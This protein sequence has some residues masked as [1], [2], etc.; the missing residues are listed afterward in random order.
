METPFFI[1]KK[2]YTVQEKIDFIQK[3]NQ[4]VFDLLGQE[5][6]N[7]IA[8]KT[9]SLVDFYTMALKEA[10][11]VNFAAKQALQQAAEKTAVLHEATL[12]NTWLESFQSFVIYNL[13]PSVVT[14]LTVGALTYGFQK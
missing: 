13:L 1:L 3:K 7:S 11:A 8:K 2:V 4:K 5:S 6:L 10:D 14:A 12:N 9:D